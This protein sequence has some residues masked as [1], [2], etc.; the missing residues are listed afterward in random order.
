VPRDVDE[1]LESLIDEV[2]LLWNTLVQRGEHL[3][4]AEPISM[5]MRAVL[6]FLGRHGPTSVPNIA[7]SRRVSRQHI[8]VQVNALTQ[9]GCVELRANPAHKRSSLVALTRRGERTLARMR[10]REAAVFAEAEIE[11]S[12]ARLERAART[13]R[14]VREALDD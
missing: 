9:E 11:A 14:A 6:E 3:H 2:R 1:S 7:R 8:Q 13:L 10:E 4:A 5:G 12:P